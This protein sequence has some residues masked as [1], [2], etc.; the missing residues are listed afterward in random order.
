MS[1]PAAYSH[2]GIVDRPFYPMCNIHTY[3]P[4]H[5]VNQFVAQADEVIYPLL[6]VAKKKGR[7]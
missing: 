5:S 6:K 4:T 1:E 7:D 2:A 3:T